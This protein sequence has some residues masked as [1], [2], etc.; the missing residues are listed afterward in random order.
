MQPGFSA[1]ISNYTR[2]GIFGLPVFQ[3]I[4]ANKTGIENFKISFLDHSFANA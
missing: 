1:E 2:Y 4:I 3:L